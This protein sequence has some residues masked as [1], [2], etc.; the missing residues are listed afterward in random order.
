[1]GIMMGGGGG[2]TGN[3]ILWGCHRAKGNDVKY[4]TGR[5]SKTKFVYSWIFPKADLGCVYIS[6]SL[7]PRVFHSVV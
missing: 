6:A 5:K 7:C 3:L 2:C 4:C 1:M